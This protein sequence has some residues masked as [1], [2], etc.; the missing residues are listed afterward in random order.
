MGGHFLNE[1]KLNSLELLVSAIEVTNR[2][3]DFLKTLPLRF[4]RAIF[5]DPVTRTFEGE[6]FRTEAEE[7]KLKID[8]ILEKMH[9]LVLSRWSKKQQRLFLSIE[10][11]LMEQEQELARFMAGDIKQEEFQPITFRA[12]KKKIQDLAEEARRI[13]REG[14]L[15][16]DAQYTQKIDKTEQDLLHQLDSIR[17]HPVNRRFLSTAIIQY[18]R[19][20]QLDRQHQKVRALF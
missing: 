4:M 18:T 6:V 2:L 3:E 14:P 5:E 1:N 10:T 19:E 9:R 17:P 15:S 12:H 13:Q 8:Q 20:R 11:F 16:Y 7:A